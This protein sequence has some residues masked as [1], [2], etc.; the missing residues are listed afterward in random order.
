MPVNNEN[1]RGATG[2]CLD[3]HDLA[4]SKLVTGRPKDMEFLEAMK[5][6]RLLDF[7]LLEERLKVTNI[8]PSE[9]KEGVAAR[10]LRLF[11]IRDLND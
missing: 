4:V 10:L 9:S 3:A 2:W 8:Q 7:A 5:N 1:T 6:E 11:M